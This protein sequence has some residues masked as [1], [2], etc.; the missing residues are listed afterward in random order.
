MSPGPTTGPSWCWGAPR[1]ERG[2]V[3]PHRRRRTWTSPA[4]AAPPRCRARPC[5]CRGPRRRSWS[6]WAALSFTYQPDERIE[7]RGAEAPDPRTK[8]ARRGRRRVT[9]STGPG[10]V[11]GRAAR[12][13]RDP[14]RTRGREDRLVVGHR[15][16]RRCRHRRHRQVVRRGRRAPRGGPQRRPRQLGR[17]RGGMAGA[18]GG[19]RARPTWPRSR[20]SRPSASTKLM[21]VYDDAFGAR[22]S[23]GGPG[24]A[25]PARLRPPPAVPPRPPDA[26]PVCSSWA[27][28]LS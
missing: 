25:G 3:R 26:Y 16:R 1:C 23:V 27:W 8:R 20:R 28:C 15:R 4:A 12:G 2:P 7:P 5:A 13:R 10:D 11:T 21:R 24:P 6:I 9:R 22:G 17:H 19:V 18:R 14:A